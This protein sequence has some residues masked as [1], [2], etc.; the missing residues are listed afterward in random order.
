MSMLRILNRLVFPHRYCFGGGGGGTTAN[1]VAEFK[2]PEYT[3]QPWQDYL[4][5]I[6]QFTQQPQQQYGGMTVAPIN[7]WQQQGMN[8]L[9]DNA[10]NGSPDLNS[11]RGALTGITGGAYMNNNPWLSNDATNQVI[12]DNANVMANSYARGT[13]AQNDSMFAR[14]GAYGGSAWQDKQSADAAGLSNQIGQMAN[15][16]QLQRTGMGAQ[17][18]SNGVNQMIQAANATGPLAATDQTAGKN[19][20][21]S[22]D[23]YQQNLQNQLNAAQAQWTSQSQYPAQMLDIMRSGLQAASG[24]FGTNAAQSSQ[25]YQ[26]NPISAL[27]GGGAAAYGLLGG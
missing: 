11:A 3:Q 10:L 13:A 1:S 2:P 5:G 21:A 23:A 27:L 26:V 12:S 4:S 19:L 22:G 20:I 25:G 24:G 7:G 16:Y 9:Q 8:L 6:Q 17:D 14:G 18:Y 15:Q